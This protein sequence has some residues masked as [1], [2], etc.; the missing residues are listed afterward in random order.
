MCSEN[1]DKNSASQA[2]GICWG[3]EDH[4]EAHNY[5]TVGVT[6]TAPKITKKLSQL[7]PTRLLFEYI[8]PIR[9]SEKQM[10]Y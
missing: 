3:N 2:Q 5:P 10:V 1:E 7:F 8:C 9:K 6:V 4:T